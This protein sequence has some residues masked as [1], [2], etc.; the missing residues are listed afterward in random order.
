MSLITTAINYTNGDPHIGHCYE[1]VLADVIVRYRKLF[2]KGPIFFQTGTDEHGQ[3]IAEKA[4]SQK[5]T[6]KELCDFYANK[7][8]ELDQELQ[9]SYNHFIR[10]TDLYHKEEVIKLFL[11]LKEQ[12]DI[13]LGSYQGWYNT[14]EE[15]F[16][17]EHDAIQTKYLD[18]VTNQV[19][20]K[21]T[22]PSYFFRLKKYLPDV[23]EHLESNR[24]FIVPECHHRDICHRL[25][26]YLNSNKEEEG[27]DNKI[28]DL[29]ISRTK[30]SWG[31]PIPIPKTI[32]KTIPIPIPSLKTTTSDVPE[33]SSET[34]KDSLKEEHC[35]YVWMD[36]LLNY[37]TGPLN[38][39]GVSFFDSKNAPFLDASDASKVSSDKPKTD[40]VHIIGKDILWFHAV[41]WM[42]F[43]KALNFNLP[44]K[45]YVHDFIVDKNGQKMSKSVGNVVDP[46]YLLKKYGA[47]ALRF[48]LIKETTLGFDMKFS[49]EALC[50][51]IPSELGTK[52]G[53]VVNR[54]LSIAGK[55]VEGIIPNEQ[56]LP[57]EKVTRPFDAHLYYDKIKTAL[58]EYRLSNIVESLQEMI[59][60]LNQHLMKTEIWKIKDQDEFKKIGVPLI[61]TYLEAI[62]I[63][64]QFF[65]PLL[66]EISTSIFNAL[67]YSNTLVLDKDRFWSQLIPGIVIQTRL[68]LF[69]PIAPSQEVLVNQDPSLSEENSETK[70]KK[71]DKK[72]KKEKKDKKM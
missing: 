34:S 40:I 19:L 13:Y 37:H 53:N 9:I 49:E 45:I 38:K 60:H 68:I 72:D 56:E 47:N 30:I 41:I 59:H 55:Y 28:D 44:S 17:S 10:T 62:L 57:S 31:I 51:C 35:L 32:P 7:F 23:L 6:P 66:P 54:V 8:K 29:S 71:K 12:D 61:K 43:L 1:A 33:E 15:T 46:V 21:I 64:A 27:R 48:Y 20:Q 3:K 70:S 18:P 5:V 14:R 4:L 67:K 24:D 42:A 63:I 58:N 2:E 25:R 36:A 52:L 11:R 16:V 26:Q 50:Q 65:E 22:E 39:L 69:P